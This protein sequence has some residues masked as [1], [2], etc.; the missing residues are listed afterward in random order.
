[1][2]F[3]ISYNK[4]DRQRA[5]WIARQLRGANYSVVI[6]AD[7]FGPG[8]NFVL[9]MDRAA[10]EA[11]RTTAVLPRRAVHAPGVGCG[12]RRRSNWKEAQAHSL[13]RVRVPNRWAVGADR[14]CAKANN[15]RPRPVALTILTNTTQQY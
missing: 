5:E 9:E 2:N 12:L 13:T 1:L 4:A 11:E 3:F 10:G 14:G 8:S 6:Q 7:E 15:F